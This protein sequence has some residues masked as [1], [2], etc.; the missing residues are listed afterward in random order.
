MSCD[1]DTFIEAL[2]AEGLPFSAH[3]TTPFTHHEWYKNRAV[4]GH[5]G[6]P[7]TCPLYAGDPNRRFELPNWKANNQSL[8]L[9]KVHE[10][11]TL[12]EAEDIADALAKAEAAFLK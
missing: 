12:R 10:G 2:K 5:S 1:L 8:F 7:W 3:Y 9:I 4:F 6:Y 11:M